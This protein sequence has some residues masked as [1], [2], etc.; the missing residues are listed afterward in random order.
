VCVI[1]AVPQLLSTQ[2]LF[3]AGS[4]KAKMFRDAK[5]DLDVRSNN[6]LSGKD[7]KKLQ[8]TIADRFD[9]SVGRVCGQQLS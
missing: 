8:K 2:A 5:K 6:K 4:D 7:V 1:G 9:L 3:T